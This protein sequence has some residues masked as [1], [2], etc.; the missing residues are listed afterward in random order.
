MYHIFHWEVEKY[1][2]SSCASWKLQTN[3]QTMLFGDYRYTNFVQQRRLQNTS[4]KTLDWHCSTAQNYCRKR[5]ISYFAHQYRLSFILLI[6]D[7]IYWHMYR[8]WIIVEIIWER[9]SF[10]YYFLITVKCFNVRAFPFPSSS[11]NHYTKY[12]SN[13]SSKSG[14]TFSHDHCMWWSFY[15]V[16]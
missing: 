8:C 14:S 13:Y 7:N 12:S 9:S 11:D 2:L 5:N 1:L 16:H 15:K 10:K 3:A 6:F 4:V